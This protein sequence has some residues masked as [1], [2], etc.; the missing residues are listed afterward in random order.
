METFQKA[1]ACLSTG[2]PAGRTALVL[3][4]LEDLA[5]LRPACS[6][7]VRLWKLEDWR[8]REGERVKQVDEGLREEERRASETE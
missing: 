8:G 3:G 2:H 7:S 5:L 4:S 1:L 6:S